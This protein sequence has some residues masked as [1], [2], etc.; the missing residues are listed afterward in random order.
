MKLSIQ[1][2]LFF[3]IYLRG[4]FIAQQLIQLIYTIS[5]L[6]VSGRY[7]RSMSHLF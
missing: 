4:W 7:S 1:L 5:Y 2:T 3:Y 6:G